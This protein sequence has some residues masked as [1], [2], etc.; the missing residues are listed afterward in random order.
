MNRNPRAA[1]NSTNC[2]SSFN[3]LGGSVTRPTAWSSRISGAPST[4]PAEVG[5]NGTKV[6][7]SAL[8]PIGDIEGLAWRSLRGPRPGGL[9]PH[10]Q[11]LRFTGGPA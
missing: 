10:V 9:V 2:R 3:P 4:K 6:L 1:A 11:L 5:R 7:R 8:G